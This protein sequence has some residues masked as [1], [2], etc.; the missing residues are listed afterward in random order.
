MAKK[1][2][3]GISHPASLWHGIYAYRSL[4]TTVTSFPWGP[5]A[6]P[7][8][9]RSSVWDHTSRKKCVIATPFLFS[10]F[11]RYSLMVLI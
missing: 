3:F 6:H 5:K 9:T 11:F 2:N 1:I 7:V 10:A 4:E 8:S